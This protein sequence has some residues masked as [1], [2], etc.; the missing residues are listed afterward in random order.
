MT[1]E[2]IRQPYGFWHS[3]IGARRMAQRNRLDDVQFAGDGL[4]WLENRGK[5]GQLVYQPDHGARRDVLFEYSARG[6]VG[7]GGGEFTGNE[8]SLFFVHQGRQIMRYD[9][10]TAVVRAVTPAWGAYSTPLSSPDGRWL[11]F[12]HEDGDHGALGL[13][14]ADGG[15]P[16]RLDHSADFYMQPVWSPDGN[17]LAWVEWENPN[18]PWDATRLVLANLGGEPPH[19]VERF[20]VAGGRSE[21]VFTQPCFSPDGRQLAYLAAQG[22]WDD[23]MLFDTESGERRVVYAA[24]G[25]HLST[26]AW[27]QGQRSLAWLPDGKRMLVIRNHAGMAELCEVDVES[28][29][30]R[31]IPT[32]PFTWLRQL[33]VHPHSGELAVLASSPRLAER[34]LRWEG[35]R[36]REIACTDAW[37]LPEEWFADP[38]AVEC[39]LPDGERI[40]GWFYP[41]Q[42]PKAEGQGLPPFIVHVHGGPTSAAVLDFPREAAY[43]TSRG[44]AWLEVNHRGSSGYGRTYQQALNGNWGE[45]DVAD[46]VNLAR[47]VARQGQADEQRMVVMGGSAGGF[48]VLNCLVRYPGV[49]KAGIALY[50][51]ADLIALARETHRFERYYTDRLIAPFPE[52]A[53][54]YRKRSP[55]EQLNQMRDALAIFQGEEDKAVP[56]A[57][58]QA[59]VERL[60]GLGVPHL[61][62]LYP[63]EGHGFRAPETIEDF[64][65]QTERFLQDYVLFD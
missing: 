56:P 6:G 58:N 2:K 5:Q 42:N 38:Q 13:V 55:I 11:V 9:F 48:T 12:V 25:Y 27:V 44:Y 23:L 34:I 39:R 49:F 45:A 36:W 21:G 17:R 47:F 16:I 35:A 61:F 15:W 4:V 18:M 28:G 22:E 19:V 26:P 41:P 32:A 40:Y 52:A 54:L 37:L 51:V 24:R 64:Y 33:S 8:R 3:I 43:F 50:P 31:V 7:Y 53:A 57:Q 59:L 63:G 60:R 65:Q 10:D 30:V 29:S 1:T 62:R 46:T 14:E 20:V